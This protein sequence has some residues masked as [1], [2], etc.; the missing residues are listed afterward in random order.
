MQHVT[1]RPSASLRINSA[2]GLRRRPAGF[3][4]AFPG[5]CVRG[6]CAP[7]ARVTPRKAGRSHRTGVLQ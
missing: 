6:R 1:L 3:S 7:G 2:K 5:T 4:P